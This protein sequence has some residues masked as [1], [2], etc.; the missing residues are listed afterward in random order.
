MTVTIDNPPKEKVSQGYFGRAMKRVED[1][2]LI[3]GIATYVDDL[4]LP[5]MLH[6]EFVR[7]P[8]ANAKINSINTDGA[9]KLPGVVGIFT[10]AD[11]NDKV[12]TIPCAAPLPGGKSPDHTVLAGARVYFVGHPVAVVVAADRYVARDAAE[13]NSAALGIM[14]SSLTAAA[15][16]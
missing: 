11:L 1:P 8:H 2:R 10:G 12:G 13:A 5:G 6:A 3:K 15:K 9:K 4:K 7:S 16:A 14:R